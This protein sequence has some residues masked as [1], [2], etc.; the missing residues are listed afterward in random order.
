MSQSNAKRRCCLIFALLAAATVTAGPPAGASLSDQA[1]YARKVQPILAANCFAC[2]SHKEKKSKGGLM[3]DSRG[4]VLLGG[5]DGAVVVAGKP[6]ES[7]LIK[8]VTHTDNA[9]RMPPKGELSVEQ[10]AILRE[11]IARGVPGPVAMNGMQARPAGRITADDKAYWAFQPIREPALPTVADPRW[12]NNPIDRFIRARLDKEALS[13]SPPAET[14]ALIRRLCFDLTGLPPT[15]PDVAAFMAEPNDAAYERLVDRLLASKG[16]GERSARFWLDLVRYAE[17]DGYKADDYRPHAWRYRDYVIA[18]FNNDKPFDRF[19]MEQ[20]AGDELAPDDPEALIATGFL[21]LGIYEYNNRDVRGQWQSILDELTDVTGDVFLGLG[22]SCAHCHDH[23]FDPILQKDYYRLQAFYA[24]WQPHEATPLFATGQRESHIKRDA[25]WLKKTEDLRKQL[26]DLEAPVKA[27]AEQEAV[28]K[29]SADLQAVLRKSPSTRTVLEEQIARLAYRQV[30]YEFARIDKKLKGQSKEDYL[31]VARELAKFDADKPKVTLAT[32]ATDIGPAAPP[33]FVPK[34]PQQ[35]PVAP[36]FLTVL[37]DHDALISPSPNPETTGRRLALARWITDPKNPL[38][39]RVIVNRIW[40][41]H[42]GHGLV[43]HTSDFGRLTGS[44]SHPELLDYLASKFV[45]EGWSLKKLHKLIVMS[46]AYRQSALQLPTDL[47]LR[48]DPENRLLWRMN[49]RR[50]DAE[51]IR[52]AIL[53]ATGRLDLTA[54]GPSVPYSQPRRSI[55]TRVQRNTRDPLLEV[56][57][58]PDAMFGTAQRH[59]TTTPTQAL[60][61]MNSPIM[62]DHAYA[63]ASRL[64]RERPGSKAAQ[65]DLAYELLFSRA[66]KDSERLAAIA[67]LE[68]QSKLPIPKKPTTPFATGKMPTRDGFAALFEPKKQS[69]KLMTAELA[70]DLGTEFTIEGIVLLRSVADDSKERVICSTWDGNKEHIGWCLGV[71]GKKSSYQPNN[72]VLQLTGRVGKNKAIEH[73]AVFS[74]VRVELN[75][76]YF[77]AV[78]V[79]LEQTAPDGIRFYVKDLANDEEPVLSA[80]VG[81]KVTDLNAALHHV[82]LGGFDA[83][84]PHRW[85]GLLDDLRLTAAALKTEQYLINDANAHQETVAYWRFEPSPGPMTDSSLHGHQLQLRAPETKRPEQAPDRSLVDLCHLLLNANEFL[86]TD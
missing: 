70:P 43:P 68:N 33:I 80:E 16:Y 27:K 2:H 24:A 14:R 81:H 39:S 47:A 29:F 52:D 86:Y 73:E 6:D 82:V 76:P 44:P 8:A 51:Q 65:L 31:K 37:D 78:S 74:G 23:K 21:T 79:R 63:L 9:P 57:D 72:L 34:K 62:L 69:A 56:F 5:D 1:F 41:Q 36:G 22:V 83:D 55:Y 46:R 84:T 61:M 40:Q 45:K 67:F 15:P 32:T 18:S 13:S 50:L 3:L 59:V 25:A 53:L 19:V 4:A 58:V 60:L 48:K 38:T 12:A 7:L 85:D 17:S 49:T 71:T 26:A 10:V 20:L 30:E 77:V 35:G 64:E 75:K 42:F 28:A 54:S 11:W 66:P